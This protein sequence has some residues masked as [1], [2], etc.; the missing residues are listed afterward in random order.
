MHTLFN[1]STQ[2]WKVLTD[3]HKSG[4]LKRP[5]DTRWEAKIFYLQPIRFQIE[6]VRDTLIELSEN[7]KHPRS[8]SSTWSNNSLTS[9]GKIWLLGF[10]FSLVRLAS[11]DLNA[12]IVQSVELMTR[13][14]TFLKEYKANF[15]ISMYQKVRYVMRQFDYKGRDEPI[16][17][18]GPEKEFAIKFLI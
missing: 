18:K 14:L 15:Q 13:C 16:F 8:V 12:V 7:E 17:E 9:V 3:N 11:W 1:S 6:E 5:S 2:R 10:N 4:V